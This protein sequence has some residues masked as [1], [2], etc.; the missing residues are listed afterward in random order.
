V[1]GWSDE[2]SEEAYDQ[3]ADGS[4]FAASEAAPAAAD[5]PRR[6]VS[7]LADRDSGVLERAVLEVVLPLKDFLEYLEKQ[8]PGRRLGESAAEGPHETTRAEERARVRGSV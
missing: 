5:D 4:V 1:L 2:V 6:A 8:G 7:D 3:L